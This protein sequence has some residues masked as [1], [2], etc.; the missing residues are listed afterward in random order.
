MSGVGGLADLLGEGK[1][2]PDEDVDV[3]ALG[4]VHR[5]LLKMVRPAGLEP[6]LAEV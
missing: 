3:A 4:S 2:R 5:F 6:A 1:I